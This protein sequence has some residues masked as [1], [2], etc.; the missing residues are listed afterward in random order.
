MKNL[1][2]IKD[3][4]VLAGTDIKTAV[5]EAISIAEHYECVVRF[6]FNGIEI[7]VYDFSNP[8]D[9]VDYYYRRLKDKNDTL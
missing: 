2:E 1:T 5:K 9:Y 8:K 6:S 4:D 3:F 7:K